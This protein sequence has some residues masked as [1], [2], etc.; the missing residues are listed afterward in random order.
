V[1][2]VDASEYPDLLI[3]ESYG[4][5]VNG[6]RQRVVTVTSTTWT[7]YIAIRNPSIAVETA[8]RQDANAGVRPLSGIEADDRLF[9]IAGRSVRS[10]LLNR[11]NAARSVL[12]VHTDGV[13]SLRM[14]VR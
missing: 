4:W 12:I 1:L 2:V 5:P 8:A 9:D 6:C 3:Y 13:R 7:S 11:G 14:I 10:R